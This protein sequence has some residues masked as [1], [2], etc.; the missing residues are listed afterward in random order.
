MPT[1]GVPWV[2]LL[3][4]GI[5]G[6][7]ERSPAPADSKK[8]AA[9]AEEAAAELAGPTKAGGGKAGATSLAAAG[10]RPLPRTFVAR[11]SSKTCPEVKDETVPWVRRAAPTSVGRPAWLGRFCV[12]DAKPDAPPTGPLLATDLDTAASSILRLEP[13]YAELLPQGPAR[14]PGGTVETI[15]AIDDGPGSEDPPTLYEIFVEQQGLRFAPTAA[16]TLAAVEQHRPYVAIVDTTDPGATRNLARPARE[17]HGLAMAGIVDALR[18]PSGDASCTERLL[19]EQAFPDQSWG[20]AAN[21][22]KGSVWSLTEAVVA[23]VL[24][25]KSLAPGA[26]PAPL[27]INMS[28]GWEW[29]A[30]TA[31]Q[32]APLWDDPAAAP[33]EVGASAP[34]PAEEA[35]FLALGWAACEGALSIAAAGNTR[36]G[37]CDGDGP[38]APAAWEALPVPTAVQCATTFGVTVGPGHG[39]ALVYA[40][41]GVD[42]G[43]RPIV[44]AREHSIPPR[45][46]Y[47]SMTP[48]EVGGDQTVPWTGTSVATASLSA[49]AAQAWMLSPGASASQVMDQLDQQATIIDPAWRADLHA[50]GG[51]S[52]EVR[53][54]RANE[55]A[56]LSA[57]YAS[58]PARTAYPSGRTVAQ[59]APP[60]PSTVTL[61]SAAVDPS[62][63]NG[64]VVT[65][66][67]APGVSVPP[68]APWAELR[69]QPERAI[70]PSCSLTATSNS[71]AANA[72]LRVLVDSQFTVQSPVVLLEVHSQLQNQPRQVHALTLPVPNQCMQQLSSNQCVID[73]APYSVGNMS[74]PAFLMATTIHQASAFFYASGSGNNVQRVGHEI[75]V[76]K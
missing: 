21:E 56:D 18:C 44:N 47:S 34:R 62:D 63:C 40:A 22:A 31:G 48:S 1:R 29:N 74:L 66:Y 50:A 2:L 28:L 52:P 6:C 13:D 46:L 49:I 33:V 65:N 69:P 37:S 23:A 14:I 10:A 68:T 26:D 3:G 17:H 25:W 53:R 9:Q 32:L 39:G 8:V 45:V 57:V 64:R 76:L 67:A 30:A 4:L 7:D 54:V 73:L 35:L 51:S 11:V 61:T 70:C 15:E 60:D 12:Y 20:V 19:F 27:V 41:G 38:L 43:N 59:L 72:S 16:A 75:R 58:R 55:I 5:G 71:G 36:G 42:I 24:R